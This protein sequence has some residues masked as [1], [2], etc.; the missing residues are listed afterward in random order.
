MAVG[1]AFFTMS[2]KFI[3]KSSPILNT[4]KCQ[5]IATK[6]QTKGVVE[7]LPRLSPKLFFI[8]LRNIK[9]TEL[10]SLLTEKLAINLET[11]IKKSTMA[12]REKQTKE[13]KWRS[14]T[15]Y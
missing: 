1:E 11:T 5:K 8:R 2:R 7:E 14:A 6:R 12:V 9:V 13:G 4:L 15:H 10:V 3:G